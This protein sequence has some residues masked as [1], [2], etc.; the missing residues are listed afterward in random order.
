MVSEH[1]IHH[2]HEVSMLDIDLSKAYDTVEGWIIEVAL[3]RLGVPYHFINILRD[4]HLN[5]NIHTRTGY[6]NTD[7]ITPELGGC[8]QG[9]TESCAIFVAIMDLGLEVTKNA[10]V[11]PYEIAGVDTTQLMYCDDATYIVRGGP[12]RLRPIVNALVAFNTIAS[13]QINHK[14]SFVSTIAWDG[15][16]PLET[17]HPPLQLHT[18]SP[19]W[20][21]DTGGATLAW[22]LTR[23]TDNPSARI[24][25][26]PHTQ[27]YRHLGNFQSIMGDTGDLLQDVRADI[28]YASRAL[29]RTT[30][31]AEHAMYCNNSIIRPKVMYKLKFSNA[32]I[33]SIDGAQKSLKKTLLNKAGCRNTLSN[34]LT[35]STVGGMG[36]QRLSDLVNTERLSMLLHILSTKQSLA[37][38]LTVDAVDRLQRLTGSNQPVLETKYS[39][40]P[41]NAVGHTWIS[42]LWE[43]MSANN[44]AVQDPDIT[45]GT[46]QMSGTCLRTSLQ[47]MAHTQRAEMLHY[48]TTNKLCTTAD[49]T[50]RDGRTLTHAVR[51]DATLT[52][53]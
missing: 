30:V 27:I 28:A 3:R 26:I 23:D 51:G 35:W 4:L 17:T 1:A 9:A 18:Y 5:H 48:L 20:T 22:Q 19:K 38:T 11:T 43:W 15:D 52:S 29:G 50:L 47:G 10:N 33:D 46:Q 42:R 31:T 40:H 6:G 2:K 44:I 12:E 21:K 39:R 7:G 16:D 49:L 24:K 25:C 37:R 53:Y 34:N 8:P 41:A 13:L 32:G 45:A 36:F 14:K